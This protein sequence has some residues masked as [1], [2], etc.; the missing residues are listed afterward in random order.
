MNAEPTEK[1][2]ACLQVIASYHLQNKSA[3]SFRD[4]ME[5]MGYKHVKPIQNHVRHLKQ[6]GMVADNGVVRSLHLTKAGETA[7][8]GGKSA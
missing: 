4:I 8:K 1:Q 2:R 3:P 5:A 7:L 6:K